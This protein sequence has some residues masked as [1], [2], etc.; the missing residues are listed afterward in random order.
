[1]VRTRSTARGSEA[2]G[3]TARESGGRW[4]RG[5]GVPA[6]IA[7]LLTTGLLATAQPASAVGL[8]QAVGSSS[9]ALFGVAAISASNVWAVGSVSLFSEV[10]NKTLIMHWNGKTWSQVAS[11]G[12]VSGNATLS[13]VAAVSAR[14]LWAVGGRDNQVLILH[15]DGKAW[16]QVASPKLAGGGQ[17]DGV[18]A[19]SATDIWAV[20]AMSAKGTQPVIEHWNGKSWRRVAAPA[21][22]GGSTLVAVAVASTSS[23]WAVGDNI[24]HNGSPLIEHWNGATWQVQRSPSPATGAL[25]GVAVTSAKNAWAVS[26]IADGIADK[27]LIERWNGSMWKVQHS[28]S[29]KSGGAILTGVAAASAKNAWAVGVDTDFGFS[30]GTVIE[31]W[32]GKSWSLQHSPVTGGELTAVAVKAGQAWAVGSTGSKAIIERWTGHAWRGFVVK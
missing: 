32:N 26:G 11:P 4:S 25:I 2:G 30:L 17:L 28:A 21:V 9:S 23:I 16:K 15:W 27:T 14:D 6:L 29:P 12:P 31:H 22:H 1:M 13:A 7:W 10:K 19:I 18:A 8:D 24:G 3:L 20:G 5:R